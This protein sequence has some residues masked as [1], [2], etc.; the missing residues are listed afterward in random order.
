MCSH[1]WTSVLYRQPA[2]KRYGNGFWLRQL[3]LAFLVD[4]K[5]TR[6]LSSFLCVFQWLLSLSIIS[7]IWLVKSDV[8]LRKNSECGVHFLRLRRYTQWA[9]NS[10][11]L[12][13]WTKY[14]DQNNVSSAVNNYY[15][16]FPACVNKVRYHG[17]GWSRVLTSETQT[18]IE[19][20]KPQLMHVS[21]TGSY[22]GWVV[23]RRCWR[24]TVVLE[25]VLLLILCS[26]VWM[27]RKCK[28]RR[29]HKIENDNSVLLA[30][31]WGVEC[32]HLMV[33]SF[34]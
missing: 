2:L 23:T 16:A 15:N 27:W 4:Q 22:E 24:S 26:R 5:T 30:W 18:R 25:T 32:G 19:E 3:I 29:V 28:E 17:N 33:N 11:E 13:Q 20:S 31:H 12:R 1:P 10:F 14:S 21:W 9:S 8:V 6:I 34:V 7:N